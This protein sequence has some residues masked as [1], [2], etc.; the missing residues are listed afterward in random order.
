MS[1]PGRTVRTVQSQSIQ[2]LP[3]AGP[4]RTLAI[5]QLTNAI[6]DGAYLVTSALYFTRVVGLTPTQVGLGL[7]LGWAA[8]ILAGV[9]LGHLADRKGPRGTAVILGVTTAVAVLAFLVVTSQPGFIL[10]VCAYASGQSGLTAARQA[11]LAR[12]VEPAA[13]TVV[14]A[15]IQSSF[16]AGLAIGAALGGVALYLDTRAAYLTVLSLDAAAVLA[17]ALLLLLRLP[18]VRPAPPSTSA[19]PRLAV[20]RDRPYALVTLLN[21]VMMLYLPL[22]SLVIPLWIA[23]RT[24]APRW[25]AAAM[26]VLNTVGVMLFQVRVARRI[27]DPA[28][29]SRAVRRA[30]PVMLVACGVF[31]FSAAPS[32][33]WLAALILVAG[34]VLQ[35][36]AEMCQASGA[37]EISFYLAPPDKHGQ[38][39][40]FF[41][42]GAAA[43]RMVGPALLTGLIIAGGTPGWLIFGGI[44]L[45]AACAMGPAV[46][47]A[48]RPG[49]ARSVPAAS[50]TEVL[51]AAEVVH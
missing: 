39:Q 35:V 14:R 8:G 17:G 23:E 29:A 47:W 43:A 37:W 6:G 4:P 27:T 28:R 15:F 5:A 21:A 7:T 40:G 36:Y 25:M 13:R 3:P 34:A 18:A 16:N 33:P 2:V 44:F 41:G 1:Y 22:L 30:G 19:E 49:R 42:T 26:L 45:L 20:L 12:L 31:A 48:D 11:L 51:A 38:Y 24:A 50:P 32:A 46:R 9:P 10:A